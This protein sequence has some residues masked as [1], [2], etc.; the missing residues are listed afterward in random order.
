MRLPLIIATAVL[1]AVG[2]LAGVVVLGSA[3]DADPPSA[4][5]ITV[6]APPAPPGPAAGPLPPRDADGVVAPP[7]VDGDDDG[8]DDGGD[9]GRDRDD[10]GDD[11]PDDDD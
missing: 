6:E 8:D 3:A 4:E 5:P 11:G 9:D 10:A 7:P 1:L 2:A